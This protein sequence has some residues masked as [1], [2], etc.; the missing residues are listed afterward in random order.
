MQIEEIVSKVKDLR[1]AHNQDTQQEILTELLKFRELLLEDIT[2]LPAG[3]GAV[4]QKE[5]E[6]YQ[7]RIK[8]LT[9]SYLELLE[10]SE[11]EK[12]KL[13]IENEKL[14]YRVNHLKDAVKLD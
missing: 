3:E 8:H 6:K 11:E 7:Y 2:N 13:R 10:K 5:V 12:Q 14:R 9:K 4:S 1:E